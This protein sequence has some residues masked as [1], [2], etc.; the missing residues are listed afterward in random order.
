MLLAGTLVEQARLM[1][2]LGGTL[3]VCVLVSAADARSTRLGRPVG[4]EQPGDAHD[5]FFCRYGAAEMILVGALGGNS[6]GKCSAGPVPWA[7]TAAA[8]AHDARILV[9]I[10]GP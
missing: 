9:S 8:N 7:F 1:L 6:R 10:L 4:W 5:V 3:C 2:G